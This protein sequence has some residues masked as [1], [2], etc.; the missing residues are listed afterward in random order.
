M[1]FLLARKL[2][3]NLIHRS[4]DLRILARFCEIEANVNGPFGFHAALHLLH[5]YISKHWNDVH[6]AAGEDLLFQR[7]KVIVRD[8]PNL[9]GFNRLP[10][11]AL[12]H[13]MINAADRGYKVIV[14]KKEVGN[15]FSIL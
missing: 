2:A 9:T 6:P 10:F 4:R 3:L 14:L 1:V 15:I 11:V 8:Y 7:E 12:R 13:A 5:H